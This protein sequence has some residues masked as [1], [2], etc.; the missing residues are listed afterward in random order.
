MMPPAHARPVAVQSSPVQPSPTC[1][2][3]DDLLVATQGG[4][5]HDVRPSPE[6]PEQSRLGTDALSQHVSG[7]AVP[8]LLAAWRPRS[9]GN[10]GPPARLDVAL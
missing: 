7:A 5:Q 2:A 9:L 6:A 1:R 4:D 8:L 10:L 3:A